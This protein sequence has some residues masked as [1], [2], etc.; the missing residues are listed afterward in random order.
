MEGEKSR[1]AI[2]V[3]RKEI[4]GLGHVLLFQANVFEKT[5]QTDVT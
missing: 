3:R 5:W 4:A 2:W 1:K